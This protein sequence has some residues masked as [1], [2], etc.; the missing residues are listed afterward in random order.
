[1]STKQTLAEEIYNTL[2]EDLPDVA[3]NAIQEA[4]ALLANYANRIVEKTLHTDNRWIL[5]NVLHVLYKDIFLLQTE[6]FDHIIKTKPQRLEKNLADRCYSFNKDFSMSWQNK[7][8]A[9]EEKVKGLCL[10]CFIAQVSEGDW[11]ETS[12]QR[13]K[14]EV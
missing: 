1:M 12:W 10:D 13:L 3:A 11:W 4:S 7:D 5:L 9:E 14:D 8:I 2:F 6:D